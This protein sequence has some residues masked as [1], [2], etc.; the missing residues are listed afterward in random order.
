MNWEGGHIYGFSNNLG[1]GFVN[2][3]LKAHFYF[4]KHF[5]F[6]MHF[7]FKINFYLKKHFYFVHSQVQAR[8]GETS[9]NQLVDEKI[10]QFDPV[11]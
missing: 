2:F 3:Y 11:Q 4:K 9:S 8:G 7:Y 1:L 10:S 6:K 5:Y